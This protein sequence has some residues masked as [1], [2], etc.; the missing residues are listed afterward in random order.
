MLDRNA[1]AT[2]AEVET[3]S[4]FTANRQA[5]I[6]YSRGGER[7]CVWSQARVVYGMMDEFPDGG[8]L[9]N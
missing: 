4:G 2:G 7:L 3:G 1:A 9:S 6:R 8:Q 5:W